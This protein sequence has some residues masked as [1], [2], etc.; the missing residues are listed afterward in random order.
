MFLAAEAE[1]LFLD[2]RVSE[3][4]SDSE[5]KKKN[6]V[7]LEK[8]AFLV[9]FAACTMYLEELDEADNAGVFLVAGGCF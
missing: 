9:N 2:A 7:W 3:S 4:D 6:Y 1:G 8:K 5:L